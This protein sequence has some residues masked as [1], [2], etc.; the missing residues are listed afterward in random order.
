MCSNSICMKYI[1][2]DNIED[3]KDVFKILNASVFQKFS[4]QQTNQNSHTHIKQRWVVAKDDAETIGVFYFQIIPFKGSQLKNY[5]PTSQNKIWNITFQNLVDCYLDGVNWQLAVLGNI[6][7][8]G[9]NGQY[10]NKNI[11]TST[12]WEILYD[13]GEFLNDKENIDAILISDIY[14][15]NLKGA[16]VI[17]KRGYRCFE[18][19]PDMIFNISKN[20]SNFEDYLQSISSKYR[21][22]CNK[23]MEKSAPLNKKSLSVEEVENFSSEIF[24]LYQNVMQKIDFKLAEVQASYFYK[25]KKRFPDLFSIDTYW[26]DKKMVGFISYFKN[27]HQLEMHLIGLDYTNNINDC[28][29][30]RILY[31][32]IKHGIEGGVKTIHFGRTAGEIKSVVGAKP[33]P[34]FSFLKHQ[35]KIS[36]LAIKPLTK[37]LKAESFIVRKPF[38]N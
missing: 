33:I 29:Y 9:D 4:F 38:K 15:Q 27:I 35:Q 13:V 10:W 1:I 12:K 17:E 14:N 37:Y 22:R 21:V 8:T 16:N 2:T 24:E 7:I 18:V 11:S 36:N 26:K 32:A 19:E 31:D 34:V 25:M 3:L 30:Q 20:W 5:I 6:F 23:V 28:I